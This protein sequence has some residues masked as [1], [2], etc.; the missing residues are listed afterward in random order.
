[1]RRL[2]APVCLLV[3]SSLLSAYACSEDAARPTGGNHAGAGESAGGA[4]QGGEGDTSGDGPGA[5]ASPEGGVASSNAGG[6]GDVGAPA[7]GAGAGM[8]AG[9]VPSGAA[10]ESSLAGP[11][12]LVTSVGGPWPDSLT[13][14]C[15]DGT[16][17]SPCPQKDQSLFGQDGSYRINVPTYSV[18]TSTL[19]DQVTKLVWQ[20]IP[21]RVLREQAAAVDH[22]DALELAGETDWRLPTRLEYVSLLD[23][24][25]GAGYALPGA[26]A[27][28]ATGTFWTDS[29]SGIAPGNYYV[30]NDEVGDW[31]V[32]VGSTPFMA[33]CVRGA[34]LAGSLQLAAGVVTDSMTGLAWQASALSDAPV[35]WTEALAYCESLSLA[36]KDDW[37]LPSIKEL[38]TI[39][40][41]GATD[42]PVIGASFG[43]DIAAQYW[44]STPAPP[45]A[46]IPFAFTL[47]TSFG[48]SPRRQLT[49]NVAARCVRT[50]D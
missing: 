15:T 44:S 33:R 35:R 2:R 45:F 28:E 50:A 9:G 21:D 3:L 26:I 22:C 20:R 29:E 4:A 49:E 48:I 23:E 1:M 43:V 32:A 24:G 47:E 11:P 41:E 36:G 40:D 8:D 27:L 31:N 25:Q 7:G 18:T 42:G 17:L 13:G 37:R 39:V 5:G 10:G 46:G 14:T 12:D 16:K 38:A 34:P 30:V 6:G 19:Q